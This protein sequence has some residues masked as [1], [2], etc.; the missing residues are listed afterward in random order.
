LVEGVEPIFAPAATAD[1]PSIA[2][3][4]SGHRAPISVGNVNARA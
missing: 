3:I 2:A 1:Q 4:S